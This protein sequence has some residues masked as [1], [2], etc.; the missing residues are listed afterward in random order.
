MLNVTSALVLSAMLALDVV[1]AAFKP[2][3]TD[4]RKRPHHGGAHDGMGLGSQL[5]MG[6]KNITFL[7]KVADMSDPACHTEP[8]EAPAVDFQEFPPYDDQLSA[9][10]R[11]RQQRSVNL[12]SWFVHESWMTPSVFNCAAGDGVSELDIASGWGSTASARAVLERHWDTFITA[13]DFQFLSTVGINTVRLPIGYWNLGPE[14][15]KDTAFAGVADVYQ[16]S[17]TRVVR[18][19]NMAG[20]H[21]IGVLVDL[22]GAVGSQNGQGHSGISDGQTGLFSN[23]GNMDKTINVL[24]YLIK[25]LLHVNN[26]VGIEILNEPKYDDGLELFYNRAIDAMRGTD[27]D[28]GG[29]PLYIHNA[30]D[31]NRFSQYMSGRWDFTVQD[32]HSYFV[33]TDGDRQQSAV[34]HV[35]DISSTVSSTLHTA[36][37]KVRRNM[38]VGEFSCA[39][40]PESM[41]GSSAHDGDRARKDFCGGQL[42]IYADRTSGWHFWSYMKEDC[43]QDPGWCFKSAVGTVLPTTFFT[44]TQPGQAWSNAAVENTKESYA[45]GINHPFSLNREDLPVVRKRRPMSHAAI[46]K[47]FKLISQRRRD[48]KQDSSADT[49]GYNDGRETAQVFAAHNASKLGFIDQYIEVAIQ[50]LGP[51]KVAPGTEG[52]YTAGFWRGLYEVQDTIFIVKR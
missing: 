6:P 1:P 5:L 11:Y 37:D 24:T 42:D 16:G 49:T 10:F 48:D 12:G 41:A 39:L 22:H 35:R 27:P 45:N 28:A 2:S 34:D 25:Q 20:M 13:S 15:C 44:H 8:Y 9:V 18:A 3:P 51:G 43:D 32:Q 50:N 26:V 19:I 47:R 14:F 21:G 40:T 29:F 7:P 38:V 31:M 33:Y 36:S 17:W 4:L 30:F 52:Q 46:A 23:P